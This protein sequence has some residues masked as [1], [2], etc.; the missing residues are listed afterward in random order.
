[1]NPKKK[2]FLKA[3]T[4][5]YAPLEEVMNDEDKKRCGLTHL[6]AP[7][8]AALNEWFDKNALLGQGPIKE[9]PGLGQGPIKEAPPQ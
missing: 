2:S 9:G 1:M 8:W 7:E 4:I 6:K 3:A 5:K